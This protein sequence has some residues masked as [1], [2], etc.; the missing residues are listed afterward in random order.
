MK[1]GAHLPSNTFASGCIRRVYRNHA[2]GLPKRELGP[3]TAPFH[4]RASLEFL[5]GT[6]K[7]PHPGP[8]AIELRPG[9]WRAQRSFLPLLPRREEG[10]GERRA[11]LL[12]KIRINE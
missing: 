3:V 1:E 2:F 10:A 4:A 8:T 5:A 12:A 6:T 9:K 11:V 7:P